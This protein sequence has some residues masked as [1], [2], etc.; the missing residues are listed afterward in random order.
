MK[1]NVEKG[2]IRKEE[3]LWGMMRNILK[4]VQIRKLC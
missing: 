4:P 1:Y 3:Y 2:S